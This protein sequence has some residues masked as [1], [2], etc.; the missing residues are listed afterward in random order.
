LGVWVLHT[1]GRTNDPAIRAN[2]VRYI[3]NL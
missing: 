3:L 1:W 2:F